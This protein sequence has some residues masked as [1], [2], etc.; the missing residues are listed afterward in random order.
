MFGLNTRR[1]HRLR[2]QPFPEP[3]LTI[4][5][6]NVPY[7]TRLSAADQRELLGNIHVFLAEKNFEGCGGLALTDEIRV[8]V[9]AYACILLLH[10]RH[11]YYPRLKSILVYPE[12]YPVPVTR[13]GPGN[14]MIEDLETR[15][16]ESWRTGAVIIAWSHALR[17]PAE[18]DVGHNVI[19]HE[20]AHQLDQEDGAVNG[21]PLLP[22]TSMYATW[23]R[24]LGQEFQELRRDA[25]LDRP[26]VI[27]KYGASNPAEF[28]AVVTESF[29]EQP[30]R[31]KQRHPA[32]YE[33]L[34]EFYRQDPAAA[35]VETGAGGR[36]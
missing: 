16:G 10:R 15:A 13:R 21:A 35:E 8:T 14:Q 31:L 9:A 32:L 34:K 22:K 18:P 7:F 30:R 11:D 25:E 20:F 24:I 33:E 26:T 1:R 5:R 2:A 6:R 28:F 3:W 36:T 4:V 29:F 19:L 17:R 23:A 27:D 12:L